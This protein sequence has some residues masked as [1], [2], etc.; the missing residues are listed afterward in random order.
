MKK[1]FK[2]EFGPY[3]SE[4]VVGTIS[5]PQYNYWIKNEDRLGEYLNVFDKD[6]KEVPANAQIQKDWFEIDDLAHANGPHLDDENNTNFTI[7]ETDQNDVEISRQEHPFHTE[8]LK[9]IKVECIGKSFNHEDTILKNKFYFIGH[10]FEKGVYSTDELIK[11]DSKELTLDKLKFHYT[12]IN[13]YKI[14]HEINYDK[15]TYSIT[16]DTITNASE[17]EVFKG[18]D[19][20]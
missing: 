10:G 8:N 17:M 3:G 6:N 11:T 18:E 14:L 13:G 16:G 15:E 5:E 20:I 12:E 2:F 1:F 7:I 19:I 9:H 4:S